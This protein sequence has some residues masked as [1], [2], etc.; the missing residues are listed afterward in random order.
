MPP[1]TKKKSRIKSWSKATHKSIC[2]E[3]SNA[4]WGTSSFCLLKYVCEMPTYLEDS[5]LQMPCDTCDSKNT[6]TPVMRAR[7]RTR[8]SG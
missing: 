1:I 5:H 7:T 4:I 2:A 8:E 6:K 3:L